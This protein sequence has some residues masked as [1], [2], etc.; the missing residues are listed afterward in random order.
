MLRMRYQTVAKPNRPIRLMF[1][2]VLALAVLSLNII[3]VPP[4]HAQTSGVSYYVDCNGNDGAGGTSPASAWQSLTKANRAPLQPGDR[5]LFKRGCAWS[6]TLKAAWHGTA[7]R[8]I[9][10]GAYGSG[11][12]PK[13]HNGSTDL[14]DGYHNN[15]DI[16]GSYQTLEYLEAALVNPP[17]DPGCRNN[18]VGFFIGFNFRNP[19]NLPNGG[20][21]NVL[22]YSKASGH[23]AGVHFANNTHHDVVRANT[24]TDNLAMSQLTPLSVNASDDLGAWG[25][26]VKGSKHEI[27]FNYLAN[28]R[29]LCTYDTVEHGNAIELY[30]ARDT[31]IHHNTSVNDR[32]FSELGGSP[33]L[34]ASNN[35]YLYNLVIS[36]LP[37]TRFVVVRGAENPFGP[38]ANTKVHNNTVYYTGARSQALVCHAGCSTSILTAQNNILWA[39]EKAIFADGRIIES[40]NL[41]WSSNGQPFVQLLASSMSATSKIAN[42]GFADAAGQN[43]RLTSASPA[44]DAGVVCRYRKDLAGTALPQGSAYDIGAFEYAGG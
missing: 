26:L 19:D 3:P 10:I 30:E 23:T 14:S 41:Y 37:D 21:Y 44:I 7:E 17:V 18:P 34:R 40:N 39:E 35:S 5:L 33:A 11:N 13:I 1:V 38:T 2:T 8:R 29:A 9:L 20:S 4:A 22:R 28:N 32:V 31:V 36:S 24:V 42:P 12:L 6:G 15:V 25:M 16:A 43:Y 27:A